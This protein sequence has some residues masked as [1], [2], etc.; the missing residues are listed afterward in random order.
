MQRG[1]AVDAEAE[2]DVDVRH[3]DD[4]V[5]VDDLHGGIVRARAHAAVELADDGDDRRGG[6]LEE[7]HRPL[8]QRLGEDGV[9]RVGTGSLDL[10]DGLVHRQPVLLR[11]Q[12]DELRD[13][14]RGMRVVDLH[15]GVLVQRFGGEAALRQF[16]QDELRGAGDHEILLIDAQQA[17][18]L[19]AVIRVEEERQVVLDV[20]LVKGDAVPDDAL[21]DRV[22]VKQ[23]QRVA[24]AIRA[25]DV[26]VVHRRE[27]GLFAQPD[28]EM[29]VRAPQPALPAAP[30][31]RKLL[32]LVGLKALAEEAVV[33]AK[34]RAVAAKAQRRD[35]VEEARGQ[36]TQAA[37]AQRGLALL[38]LDLRQVEAVARER[39]LRLLKQPQADQVAREQLADQKF[40]RDIVELFVAREPR[41]VAHFLKRQLHQR[42]VDLGALGRLQRLAEEVAKQRIQFL[43]HVLILSE[44]LAP[45]ARAGQGSARWTREAS[46]LPR[47]TR[48]APRAG[49]S[50][51]PPARPSRLRAG[52]CGY[53][54]A[55][56]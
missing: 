55:R 40:R 28:G 8:F 37:V 14:H 38:L 25:G 12:A 56:Y 53:P 30:G 31:V 33:V 48:D 52:E 19:V 51:R 13:D 35:G 22:E 27:H 34:A 6:L 15:D 23:V 47:S 44:W 21:V 18:V 7:A 36:A 2:V 3:V 24:P 46:R 10:G 43:F 9:V 4:V 26:D 50:G 20:R 29:H 5:L 11:Q 16:T 1:D 42:V 49:S 17:A 39:R 32:L 45:G 54:H 41:T